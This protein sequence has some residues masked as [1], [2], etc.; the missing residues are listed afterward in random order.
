MFFSVQSYNSPVDNAKKLDNIIYIILIFERYAINM[1][2][3]GKKRESQA[4]KL[5]T[6]G[7]TA[8]TYSP[9]CA[10]PSA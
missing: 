2:V 10:V 7:K 8:T 4:V 1:L 5:K 9:T 3:S 6:L